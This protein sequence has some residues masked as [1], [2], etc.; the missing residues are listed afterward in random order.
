MFVQNA[1]KE[2]EELPKLRKTNF[3]HN[4]AENEI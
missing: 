2:R 1:E 4:A 3:I